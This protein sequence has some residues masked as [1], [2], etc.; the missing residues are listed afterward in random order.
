MN[1]L[2]LLILLVTLLMALYI[3]PGQVIEE[4]DTA[5]AWLA[6]VETNA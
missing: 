6:S 1:H 4:H 5:D 3:T 2:L